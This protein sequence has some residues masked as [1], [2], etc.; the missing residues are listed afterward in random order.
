MNQEQYQIPYTTIYKELSTEFS[1]VHWWMDFDGILVDAQWWTRLTI[2]KSRYIVSSRNNLVKSRKICQIHYIQIMEHITHKHIKRH[3]Q[4]SWILIL[5]QLAKFRHKHIKGQDILIISS[6]IGLS[7]Y[8]SL[9][10][11]TYPTQ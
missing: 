11:I 3:R 10:R 9:H 4:F 5:Y 2:V 7:C 1:N 8:L 6:F